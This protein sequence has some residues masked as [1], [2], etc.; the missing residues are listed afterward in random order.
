MSCNRY[1]NIRDVIV[2]NVEK[3]IRRMVKKVPSENPC[4]LV[5]DLIEHTSTTPSYYYLRG[6]FFKFVKIKFSPP[7]HV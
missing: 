7:S 4:E 2:V 6:G 3:K 5:L 1:I